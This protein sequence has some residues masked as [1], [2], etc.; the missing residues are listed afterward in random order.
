MSPGVTTPRRGPMVGLFE[1]HF[2]VP[3]RSGEVTIDLVLDG[4]SKSVAYDLYQC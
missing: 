3:H 1:A 2:P 4:V